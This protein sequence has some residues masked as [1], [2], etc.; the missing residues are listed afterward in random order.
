MMRNM[1]TTHG[2]EEKRKRE[3]NQFFV[4]CLKILLDL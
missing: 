4:R 2:D 1:P 3:E